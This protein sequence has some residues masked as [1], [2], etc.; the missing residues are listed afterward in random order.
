MAMRA[1][2]GRP[3]PGP[4]SGRTG[5]SVE[6]IL[7]RSVQLALS[8]RSQR[9]K[10]LTTRTSGRCSI[11]S[12]IRRGSSTPSDA[13]LSEAIDG[14]TKPSAAY[15][16]TPSPVCCRSSCA[17]RRPGAGG[18]RSK[19][20]RPGHRQFGGM[21][22]FADRISRLLAE[23]YEDQVE[24][25]MSSSASTA[26]SFRRRPDAHAFIPRPE[27]EDRIGIIMEIEDERYRQIGQRIVAIER[28]DLLTDAQRQRWESCAGSA[29]S[30][31]ESPV[32]DGC[33]RA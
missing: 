30:Q 7:R 28:P 13:D 1:K 23:R 2:S 4:R 6:R 20:I 27:L 8:R 12:S 15:R 21:L 25:A 24:P 16:S 17:G 10:M 14:A 5:S 11:S 31:R 32:D 22:N 26:V 3:S 29:S 19:P 18:S 9:T 33:F